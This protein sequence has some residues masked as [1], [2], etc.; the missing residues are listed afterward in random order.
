MD[1]AT[2]KSVAFEKIT[3]D[4]IAP[5]EK[6]VTETCENGSLS[7]QSKHAM[8]SRH[9]QEDRP[10]LYTVITPLQARLSDDVSAKETTDRSENPC[11]ISDEHLTLLSKQRR[12]GVFEG[13]ASSDQRQRKRGIVEDKESVSDRT[14]LRV[15]HK[16]F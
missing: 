12:H 6:T 2:N 9:L 15:L 16:K 14:F 10:N 4:C 1:E 8:I 13:D 3:F 11:E 7:T 5:R